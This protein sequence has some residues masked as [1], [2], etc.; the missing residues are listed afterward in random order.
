[1]TEFV[2]IISALGKALTLLSVG[3][4]GLGVSVVVLILLGAF[5]WTFVRE[6]VR[7]MRQRKDKS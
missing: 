2:T 5:L 3:L 4:L 1:M 7:G 6:I